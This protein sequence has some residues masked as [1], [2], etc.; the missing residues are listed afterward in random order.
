MYVRVSAKPVFARD[1]MLL[2]VVGLVGCGLDRYHHALSYLV[3]LASDTYNVSRINVL[4]GVFWP[5]LSKVM[6][7]FI[8]LDE[9]ESVGEDNYNLMTT[10][11]KNFIEELD[12]SVRSFA[13]TSF[14]YRY[15]TNGT[16]VV[17]SSTISQR[18]TRELSRGRTLFAR[19]GNGKTTALLCYKSTVY[20]REYMRALCWREREYITRM[21]ANTKGWE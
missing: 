7:V 1:F 21:E 6:D 10:F 9:S 19:R 18:R 3:G 20:A 4:V 13:F 5:T 16:D 12:H 15:N 17:P 2:V 14:C 8:V 11:V